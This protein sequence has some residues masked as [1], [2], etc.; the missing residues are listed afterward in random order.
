LS[1]RLRLTAVF[2]VAMAVVLAA[3]AAF[4]HGWLAAELLREI[5]RSLGAQAD[6]L[7]AGAPGPDLASSG[8]FVDPDEAFAQLLTPAGRVLEGSRGLGSAPALTPA[9]VRSV[10]AAHPTYLTQ[11][12]NAADADHPVA[13]LDQDMDRLL[14]TPITVR[15]EPAVLVVGQT[16]SDRDEALIHQLKLFAVALPVAL[17]ITTASG[18]LLAGAAL[19]PV[20]S[21]RRRGAELSAQDPA[22]RLPV[23][24]TGDELA[25]LAATLNDLL[26]RLHRAM[27]R[28]R[29][30]VDDASHELRTPLAVLKAELD[31]AL[32]R[33]RPPEQLKG[34]LQAA[35]TYTDELIR[36]AE[37]LLVLARMRGGHL[38]LHRVPTDLPEMLDRA[39]APLRQTAVAAGRTVRIDA[40]DVQVCLDPLRTRQAVLNLVDN[41]LRHGRGTITVSATATPTSLTIEVRDEG[42]GFP[43]DLADTAFEP[44]VRGTAPSPGPK[45]AGLGLAIVQAVAAAHGG[46]ARAT[47]AAGG[48]ARVL[49]HLP[50]EPLG[51][52][53][54]QPGDG[55][56]DQARVP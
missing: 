34:A 43:P 23:P 17:I 47:R 11:H 49:V 15:G 39:V 13:D 18:W 7:L 46:T 6:T 37:D 44:F 19:R 29:R 31:L 40:P 53:S 9:Q 10:S 45:G 33:P 51:S 36:L 52:R 41:A 48:G 20:E 35:S 16:L 12:V 21:M 1:L 26:E 22:L 3:L 27:E 42:D 8:R 30:F 54:P 50:L 56:L 28:E 5:D 55:R 14:A 25:R 32:S 24:D 38:P 4:L 2:A